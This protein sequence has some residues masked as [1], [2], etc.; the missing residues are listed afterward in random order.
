MKQKSIN[1]IIIMI[2]LA[3]F[4]AACLPIPVSQPAMSGTQGTLGA[5][6]PK[7]EQF[8]EALPTRTPAPTPVPG[9]VVQAVSVFFEGIGLSD[10]VILGLSVD[11][12]ADIII[13]IVI[14]GLIYI[15]GLWLVRIPLRWLIRR[16][17]TEFDDQFFPSVRSELRILVLVFSLDFILGRKIFISSASYQRLEDIFFILYLLIFALLVWKLVRFSERWY[18]DKLVNKI[19]EERYDMI[20]PLILRSLAIILVVFVFAILLDHIG[21]QVS[22]FMVVGLLLLVAYIAVQFVI[23]DAV[24]GFIILFD[25]PFRIGDR[26]KIQSMDTWGDVLEI[27]T[28]TTRIHTL[29][30][31]LVVVP[32]STIANQQLDNYTYPD[33]TY[34]MQLDIGIKFGSDIQQV[35]NVILSAVSGVQGVLPDKPLEVLL[36][37]FG[38]SGL[39]FRVRWWVVT[40]TDFYVMSNLVNLAMIEAMENAGI[41]ISFTTLNV[42]NLQSGSAEAESLSTPERREIDQLD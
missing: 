39:T 42:V 18:R 11:E 4:A 34:R 17:P 33:P 41:E 36:I 31:R 26:V 5:I 35:Q 6:Q 25:Q 30:N 40:H 22:S 27:G 13:G 24:N 2:G 21:Y 14:F 28:R 3:V 10:Q 16:T 37:E 38:D 8:E 29:D 32:N 12:W 9:P 1:T 7:L 20:S 15:I 19:G 23:A